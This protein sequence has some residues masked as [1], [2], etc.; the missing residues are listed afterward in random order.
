MKGGG[1]RWGEEGKHLLLAPEPADLEEGWPEA[2]TR[3]PSQ[4]EHKGAAMPQGGPLFPT[5]FVFSLAKNKQACGLWGNSFA[6]H[7]SRLALPNR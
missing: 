1:E 3:D 4:S 6:S 7:P 2:P 5:S